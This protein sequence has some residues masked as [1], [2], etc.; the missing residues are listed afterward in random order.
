MP[1]HLLRLRQHVYLSLPKSAGGPA[2]RHYFASSSSFTSRLSPFASLV[3]P[4]CSTKSSPHS[5][6]Q[7]SSFPGHKQ[8]APAMST[9]AI[10]SPPLAISSSSSNRLSSFRFHCPPSYACFT[11]QTK[12]PSRYSTFK[13]ITDEDITAFSSFLSSPDTQLLSSPKDDLEAFTRDYTKQYH[14]RACRLVVKPSTVPELQAIL[15][16]C[17]EHNIAVVPQGG[18]TGLV[19][20]SVPVHDEIIVSLRN[21]NDVINFNE[22]TGVLICE[23]GCILENLQKF[24]SDKGFIIPLDLGSKGSCTIGGNVS[25]AAGGIRMV[26]YGSLSG[27]VVGL[28]AVLADGSLFS[29]LSK[30]RKDNTGLKLHQLLIGGEGMLG[31][32]TKV[33]LQCPMASAD[34]QVF[35]FQCESFDKVVAASVE[36]R[37]QFPDIIS[38]VEFFDA[39]SLEAVLNQI[40]E[41]RRPFSTG[42]K[43]Y[44]LVETM[45]HADEADAHRVEAVFESLLDKE[46]VTDGVLAENETQR[47]QLWQLREAIN[48]ALAERGRVFKF[49]LTLPL[50]KMYEVVTMA[51]ERL[52]E[53]GLV[54]GQWEEE[55]TADTTEMVA[56]VEAPLT[57]AAELEKAPT[58]S[59]QPAEPVVA[60]VEA[61]GY[62]HLGDCNVHL[63]VLVLNEG[64]AHLAWA[65]LDPWVYEY[66]RNCGG[67][68]SSEHGIGLQKVDKLGLVKDRNQIVLMEKVKKVFDPK[69]ILNP[70]KVLRMPEPSAT[71][72][73]A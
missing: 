59:S 26:R 20:G 21:M 56:E 16:H 25:T 5:V 31:V 73:P 44:L 22:E 3:G 36:C 48:P 55:T 29:S 52:E 60:D 24:V 1:G 49:D 6:T 12:L 65:G 53:N 14:S 7:P 8:L 50:P 28:E 4:L 2:L 30:W 37:R 68:I 63:N 43:F 71:D 9:I 23:S 47:A 32:V 33:A 62:G 27:N 42:S 70:Y 34:T 61:V 10:P 45:G 58:T 57:E 66:T 35:L 54:V 18:N 13:A 15:G 46:L 19:G 17:H 51:K 64:K 69:G 38:A 39:L 72:G 41:S 40:P 11:T 67:S